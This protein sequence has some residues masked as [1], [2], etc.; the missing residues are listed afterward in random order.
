NDFLTSC[1]CL[2]NRRRLLKNFL[3]SLMAMAYSSSSLSEADEGFFQNSPFSSSSKVSSDTGFKPSG[4]KEKKYSK[5]PGNGDS[6]FPSTKEPRVNQE[7]DTNVNSTNNINTVS[8]IINAACIEDNDVD[9][10]IVYRCADDPNMPNLEAIVYSDDDEDMDMKSAFLYGKIEEEV[11][12]CQPSGL[13]VT[14]KDDGIFIIQDKYVDGILKK[15]GFST[16]RMASTPMETSKPLLK[17][18]EA[19]DVD[20]H[21][22]RS[23]IESLMY[24]TTS[25]PDIMFDKIT[26]SCFHGFIDKDLINLVIPN[27]RRYVVVLIG[28]VGNKMHKP[29]PLPVIEFPLPVKKVPIAE[30]KQCHCCEDCTATKVK[31]KLIQQYLQHEYY[32]LWEVI[33]FGD[34]YEAP[35]NVATTGSTSDETGKKKGR[36]VTFTTNDMQKR[37]NNVKARTT[38]LLSLP[39]E[40]QLRFIKHS[41]GNKEVNTAS[42][43]VP[44]ASA[45][46]RVIDEDDMEEMDIKWNMAFL[47]MRADRFWKKTGKKIGIQGTDVDWSY[48]ENDEENHALIADKETPTE[49]ALMAKTSAEKSFP[50]DAQNRNPS[51][52]ETEASPS[53]ISPKPFIKFVKANDSPTKRK[54]DKIETAKKPPVKYAKQYRKP[55]KKPNVRGNQ[56]NWNNM[57]SRQLGPN[58]VIGN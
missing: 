14:Q 8:L 18:A 31:K 34:S 4:E 52:T 47:S 40:H 9:E 54:T 56:R 48:M 41:R 32:A 27:V 36:M 25:R 22:Y 21:L 5:D 1:G 29:F 12:V 11:Y 37:K 50:D 30:E 58:F 26:C 49:F 28:I 55:T 6:E 53:T 23:M 24:L 2:T 15:F 19:E 10:N 43:N 13:Q 57:K 38:L 7:Q 16:V 17:D 51:V 35:T 3:N 46:I 39:D 20:V 33:E 42:T 44:T 45:N